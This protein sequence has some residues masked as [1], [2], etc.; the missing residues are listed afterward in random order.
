MVE[1][2]LGLAQIKCGMTIPRRLD[3]ALKIERAKLILLDDEFLNDYTRAPITS[4]LGI[5]PSSVLTSVTAVLTSVA[6]HIPGVRRGASLPIGSPETPTNQVEL[7]DPHR[8]VSAPTGA[9]VALTHQDGM[10]VR[11]RVP[12]NGTSEAP[13]NS[14]EMKITRY[15]ELEKPPSRTRADCLKGALAKVFGM[16]SSA[17]ARRSLRRSDLT[18]E[19]RLSEPLSEVG[20]EESRGSKPRPRQYNPK[21][22]LIRIFNEIDGATF[23]GSGDLEDIG[24]LLTNLYHIM[25]TAM[26]DATREHEPGRT[27]DPKWFREHKNMRS[28]KLSNVSSVNLSGNRSGTDEGLSDAR[29]SESGKLNST[30]L[31][32]PPDAQGES[33]AP[34]TQLLDQH[35][36]R[37][38]V[39]SNGTSSSDP[40]RR[41]TFASQLSV[42]ST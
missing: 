2:Y 31:P 12:A 25:K 36:A 40:A 14:D 11:W 9:S 13:T 24:W 6:Q 18:S 41:A 29:G 7:I 10:T 26:K 1:E 30:E 33:L 16:L 38:S 27:P 21:R 8:V 42:Q 35:R 5:K 17:A 39:S 28:R 3:R 23:T 15:E 34:S 37:S 32:A 20:D 19:I 22:L 4:E